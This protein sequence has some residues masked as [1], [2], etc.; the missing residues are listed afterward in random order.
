MA[1]CVFSV[2]VSSPRLDDSNA[3]VH[4]SG[5]ELFGLANAGN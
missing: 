3:A 4:A 2:K 5:R 1:F